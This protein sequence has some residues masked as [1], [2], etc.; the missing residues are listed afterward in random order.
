MRAIRE[1]FRI[2]NALAG[3]YRRSVPTRAHTK[4]CGVSHIIELQF[5]GLVFALR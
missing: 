5:L 4:M 1:L 3:Q 2:A